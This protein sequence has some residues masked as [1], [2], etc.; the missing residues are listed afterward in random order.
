MDN[1]DFIWDAGRLGGW[2]RFLRMD[3]GYSQL[4]LAALC[5]VTASEIHRIEAGQQEC[6][7]ETLLKLCGPLGTTPGWILDMVIQTNPALFIGKVQADDEFKVLS[8]T[9]GVGN[10]AAMALC[11]AACLAA[12][13]VRASMPEKRVLVDS[14][15][16]DRWKKPFFAFAVRLAVMNGD[17]TERA[18]I[19]HNLLERPVAELSRQGLIVESIFREMGKAGKTWKR[20][21]A[22]L[23]NDVRFPREIKWTYRR[24][25][26]RKK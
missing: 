2:L 13:L 22:W 19:L 4:Q 10:S 7:L 9:F 6:R 14:F 18:T 25:V 20:Q 1:E 12:I 23:T 5:D 16:D 3:R 21:S 8:A 15:A 17:S 24:S 11:S 26:S